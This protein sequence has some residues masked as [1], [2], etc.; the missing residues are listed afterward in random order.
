MMLPCEARNKKGNS[1]L[2]ALQLSRKCP[3]ILSSS[4]LP[5]EEGIVCTS[6]KAT[7]LRR[8]RNTQN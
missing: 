1:A 5:A 8:T 4:S 2:V 7:Q 3:L 6:A